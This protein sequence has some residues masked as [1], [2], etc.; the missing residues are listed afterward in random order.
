MGWWHRNGLVDIMN[1]A[2]SAHGCAARV[3]DARIAAVG[4]TKVVEAS[5]PP[6][7]LLSALRS[8]PKPP[9][10]LKSTPSVTIH[11]EKGAKPPVPLQATPSVAIP[12]EKGALWSAV[13]EAKLELNRERVRFNAEKDRANREKDRA[14]TLARQLTAAMTVTSA[15]KNILQNVREGDGKSFAALP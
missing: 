6:P 15:L 10:P 1:E 12:G 14:D 5:P 11:E 2:R 13:S 3:V 8:S 7:L 9:P 4:A